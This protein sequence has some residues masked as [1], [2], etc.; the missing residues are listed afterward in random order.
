MLPESPF[1]ERREM[2]LRLLQLGG[3]SAG[4][5]G[6]AVWLSGRSARPE[7]SAATLARPRVP[8]PADLS[9]PEIAVVQGGDPGPMARMAIQALGGIGRFISRGDIVVI[10]PNIAW[11]RTAGQAAN[12]NPLVVAELVRLCLDAGAAKQWLRM[13]PLTSRAAPSPAAALR[14]RRAP[15]GPR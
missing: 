8:V 1:P 14:K 12:T 2:L 11:D 10:K 9:L 15:R 3:L 13:S 4:A 7:E 5:A 6:L